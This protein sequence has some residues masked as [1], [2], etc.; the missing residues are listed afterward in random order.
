MSKSQTA[1]QLRYHGEEKQ[2]NYS[3]QLSLQKPKRTLS[4]DCITKQGPITKP[5]QT[6]RATIDNG[7]LNNNRTTA[8][9]RTT[10][11]QLTQFSMILYVVRK[12]LLCRYR[13]T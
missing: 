11:L 3:N 7:L 2:S 13:Q 9:E 4:F 1:D 12:T 5:P 6:M 8:L 10:I